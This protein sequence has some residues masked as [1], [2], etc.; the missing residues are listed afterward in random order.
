MQLHCYPATLSS[1]RAFGAPL[2]CAACGDRLIAP[3]AS[4]FVEGGE[5]RHYWE[6]EACGATSSSSIALDRREPGRREE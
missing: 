4:A 1:I 3:M 2:I 6:C 5:I